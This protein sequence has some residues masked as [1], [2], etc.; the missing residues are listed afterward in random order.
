MATLILRSNGD[1]NPLGKKWISTFIKRNPR[2]SSVIGRKIE[3]ARAEAA[4]HDQIKMFMEQ[5]EAT[6]KR[7][8]VLT[9]DIYNMD[10]TGLALG[11]MTNC[12]VLASSSK[13]RAYVKSPETREWV[14]VIECVS[15]AGRKL[16]CVAIFKGKSL[17][18]TWFPSTVLG[19][20][21]TT[22]ENGWT[23][24]VI[25]GEWLRRIF[26]P[27]T[28]S[29]PQRPR[30]LIMDGHG[31]HVSLDFLWTCKQNKVEL[32][33]LPAHS[34]HVLQPLDLTGFA[35]IK[36]N[37]RG[38]I[39]KFSTLDDAAPIKK[40]RFITC[41]NNAREER[42]KSQ[43]IRSGWRAAG[44]CTY[45]P[46]RVLGSSQVSGRPTTPQPHLQSQS[47]PNSLL[48]TPQKPHDI[49]FAQKELEKTCNFDR[50]N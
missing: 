6:G 33:F 16:R 39:T 37:Y 35:V 19:W 21:Y 32:H 24:N 50:K 14:S 30:L 4:T 8:N 22:S 41:Y 1:Q 49:H 20:F 28:A 17:Q 23:S 45:N 31:S 36:S 43:V 12:Q 13:K 38:Q 29:T 48:N 27:E 34:S 11:V 47:H 46:S 42:L 5:F 18:T 2:I 7:I 3:K 26:L 25:G 40:G 15:A 44:L 9:E 10:E